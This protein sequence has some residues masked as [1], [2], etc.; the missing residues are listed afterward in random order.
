VPLRSAATE[1]KAPMTW[2]DHA[3]SCRTFWTR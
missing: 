1:G 2:R 3:H